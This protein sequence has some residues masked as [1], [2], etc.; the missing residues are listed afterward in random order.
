M[1]VRTTNR[2]VVV[3]THIIMLEVATSTGT[4]LLLLVTIMLFMLWMLDWLYCKVDIQKWIDCN[5]NNNYS[6]VIMLAGYTRYN[7]AMNG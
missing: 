7:L 2:K 6:D 5:G 3:R 1:M 4:T